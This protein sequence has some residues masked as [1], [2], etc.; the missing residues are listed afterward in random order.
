MTRIY[1]IS[2][3]ITPDIPVYKNKPEKRPVFRITSDH[4]EKGVRETRVELDVH[5]GTHIDAPLHMIER[6]ETIES[7]PIENLITRCRVI[8]LTHVEGPISRED[9]ESAG[10]HTGEFI[11]FKTRNSKDTAFNPDFVFVGAE[12]ARYLA[13][14]KVKGVGIDALGVERSQPDHATHKALFGAGIIV[15][16]GLRL[17]DVPSGSYQMIAMPIAL[18]GIDAAPARVVLVADE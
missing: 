4:P 12:A 8:D 5:T 17:E 7:I 13:D 18:V 14:L 11:L 1:D 2:M 3:P 16:E 10:L 15:I 9:V 6:G